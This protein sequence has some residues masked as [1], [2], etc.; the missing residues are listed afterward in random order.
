MSLTN[1]PTYT[2]S[3]LT[4]GSNVYDIGTL[5]SD[6]TIEKQG[7]Y[8]SLTFD[9]S[10]NVAYFSNVTVGTVLDAPATRAFFHGNFVDTFSDGDVTTAASNGRFYADMSETT[11]AFGT[12]SVTSTT[13]TS[14]TYQLVVPTE[15]TGTNVLVV[16]GGG[17]G[18]TG[19]GWPTG[20]G[21]GE[22]QNLTNQT[23]SAGTYTIVVGNG[24][25][26]N[27]SGTNSSALGTT[28]NPGTSASNNGGTSG[29]GNGP[30]SNYG[31][32]ERGGGGGDA[33]VGGNA[34]DRTG[35]SGGDGSNVSWLDGSVYGEQVS[36][37]AYFGGGG[38]SGD[39]TGSQTN[40]K[41]NG[42]PGTGGGGTLGGIG[43][44]GMIAIYSSVGLGIKYIG[45]D[46]YNKLSLS[47]ITNPTSKI[48]ALPTGAESTTT[49]DIGS[50]TNIYI[51][52]EGTYTAEMKGATRF[53]LDSTVVSGTISFPSRTSYRYLAL[54]FPRNNFENSMQNMII[55]FDDG[56]KFD[57][58]NQPA[59]SAFTQNYAPSTG[60]TTDV[61]STSQHNVWN[62]SSLG[63]SAGTWY[64]PFHIDCGSDFT[65][66]VKR[67]TIINRISD[68][69][70][71]LIAPRL[72]GASSVPS[73]PGLAAN[74]NYVCHVE[75]IQ[76]GWTSTLTSY[77][78]EPKAYRYIGLVGY[79]TKFTMH[80]Y[81]F[82]I[83]LVD[84]TVYDGSNIPT[85]SSNMTISSGS[86]A[87][88]IDGDF[89][90]RANWNSGSTYTSA[91]QQY[92][93]L[94]VDLGSA[95]KVKHVRVWSNYVGSYENGTNS[96]NYYGSST[97]TSSVNAEG[98]SDWNR[99]G[100]IEMLKSNDTTEQTINSSLYDSKL[101]FDGYNKLSL[102]KF[103]PTS[104]TLKY[105]SNTY[106]L[107]TISNVYIAYPGTYSAE[108]KGATNFA[109][110]SNITGSLGTYSTLHDNVAISH[111][112]GGGQTL[113][114]VN[115]I[116]GN[117]T[118]KIS[119]NKQWTDSHASYSTRL[120]MYIRD[121][122]DVNIRQI[123]SIGD[124]LNDPRDGI[125][126]Y[127]AGG[128]FD[129]SAMVVGTGFS[130]DGSA[131]THTVEIT[132]G[133][134]GSTSSPFTLADPW[135]FLLTM[136]TSD[137]ITGKFFVGDTEVISHFL[138]RPQSGT[139]GYSIGETGNKFVFEF[140][141]TATISG[142]NMTVEEYNPAPKF[143][144]DTY[145][146]LTFTGLESGST[147]TLKYGSNTYDIGT[148]SNVYISE[149]GTY[150]AESKGT[151]TFALTSNTALNVTEY[152]STGLDTVIFSKI[153][154]SSWTA[155]STI[156]DI[157]L[158]DANDN[159]LTIEYFYFPNSN[160]GNGRD[161]EYINSSSG[162]L[163]SNVTDGS[164]SLADPVN[165]TEYAYRNTPDSDK[166]MSFLSTTF[167]GYADGTEIIH[168]KAVSGE[169]A[170]VRVVWDREIYRQ[171][172]RISNKGKTYDITVGSNSYQG[173]DETYTLGGTY[174]ATSFISFDT[175]NKL[176]IQNITPTSTTL[177]YGSNTYEIG[178]ATNIYVENTGDYSAEIGNATDFALTNTTVSG[179][180]KT[181][182]PTLSG[183]YFFGHALTY[184]GKLYGWGENSN[185]ELGVGDNTDKTVPTLCTGI[186][187]G[188]VVSIWN[189]SKRSQNQWAKTRDGKIWVTGEG[190]QYN[191]PGQTSNQTSFIDVTSYF[192]DQSLTANN[193]THISGHGVRTVAALT[194]TGNV[195]TWGTHISSQWNLGQGTG[196]S[197]SN[198]PKQITFGGVTDNITRFE[199]G[200]A[201]GVALDTDGDVWFWGQIW[202][203][204]AGVDYPQ[205]TLS[206]AQK[207]PHEIMTS[208]NIIG[209]SSTYFTIYAW[210]S[211][212]TYYALGQDSAG[213]IGDGTA[214]AGGHT[215]W[216]KVDYFSANNITINEIYGGAYH[217][218]AD[219]SDGYYCWGG[220]TH[221]N[222]G[223]GSTGNLASPTKWTNVSNIKVFSSGSYECPY[224]ITEDGK[225]YAWGNGTNNARGD[226]TTGD[227]TY[228]KYIDTLPNILA[229]SFDY[230]GYDKVFVN[231]PYTQGQ[232][233]KFS[234]TTQT[235]PKQILITDVRI[236]DKNGNILPIEY[237]Y[238]PLGNGGPN[239]DLEYIRPSDSLFS[240]VTDG[241]YSSVDSGALRNSPES[242]R[243][244]HAP[245]S[246]YNTYPIG[247]EWMHVKAMSGSIVQVQIVWDRQQY[248]QPT[249]LDADGMTY[250]IPQGN[251]STLAGQDST[252]T[253]TGSYTS[254]KSS[255]YT[256]D[257]HTYDT[258][259]TQI[260]T[261]SDP[262]TYDAQI[263]SGTNFNLKSATI[264]AT[265]TSGL[266]TWAFHHGNFDNAYGDGDILTARDNGRFYADTPSYTGD[267][268]TITPVN[269]LVSSNV[270]FRLNE[271]TQN[272]SSDTNTTGIML[273]EI[274]VFDDT[275]TAMTYGT[276][277]RAD[278]YRAAYADNSG[279]GGTGKL[280]D[281]TTPYNEDGSRLNDNVL[282]G[283]GGYIGW[284][285]GT[286]NA[287]ATGLDRKYPYSVDD[288]LIR[289]VPL[290]GKII[291]KVQFAYKGT[292]TTPG[293]KVYRGDNLIETTNYAGTDINTQGNQTTHQI[294]DTVSSTTYTFTPAST[295]TANVLMVAGGGGG[296]QTSGG[297]A[298]GGGA[299]GLVYTAGTSLAQGAT[300][301]I[302]VGNGGAN[303]S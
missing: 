221:G 292:G 210:Q 288:E 12:V 220:G 121:S 82:S 237:I 128:S 125:L 266:Y 152:S 47:G 71:S 300:K 282:D 109:L 158:K 107:G 123:N 10:S 18:G 14:T 26:T 224:A 218:F 291:G 248:I 29:S 233:V 213:Q 245:D 167:N 126:L 175:Y 124:Y 151:T 297:S 173:L 98:S 274:D 53:A 205:T 143:D 20:G 254:E 41:G 78:M 15:L 268:G 241:S 264:P 286:Y 272:D 171:P 24:G 182:E 70:Y 230:D 65:K 194:E 257:T 186:P 246:V 89:T 154:G 249:K 144:F 35:G 166:I 87:N 180:L 250:D 294:A 185:G 296:G 148:A 44:G 39:Y 299:G 196:A 113:V 9:T 58:A 56:T 238:F 13:S 255:K 4:Y 290:T 160:G 219:T 33:S 225:Y 199:I 90:S 156:T 229:P 8:A 52:S 2:S 134:Y 187:Q 279:D 99:L 104:S 133:T 153:S 191:I 242:N 149:Q 64:C 188:E 226:N 136:S 155:N 263:K 276:D 1:T 232:I 140:W 50:A 11:T 227:I 137:V 243:L 217:V 214:T 68:Y 178:T 60:A 108:I 298:G 96:M 119:F 293:W 72:Y 170:K 162:T 118:Y 94:K 195:W 6:I 278:L 73:T 34:G 61:F 216:Q 239:Q 23:I 295:L 46:T 163:F 174:N 138:T 17:G 36:G 3:K 267:I 57:N 271:Y 177:K 256:K 100:P 287:S 122:S 101:E 91:S 235:W 222:L 231:N 31:Q 236:K 92:V 103:D 40:G 198:T 84:G 275:N 223:N 67:V 45:F 280:S 161:L 262:G 251:Q 244:I 157:Q 105:F 247:T 202:A 303:H 21:G 208:N 260:V 273:T 283:P 285:N 85:V 139:S 252:Y 37:Q 129:E 54:A 181:V 22:V 88:T 5:T 142:V 192:G 189:K 183:G 184:D 301:T 32:Y 27:A 106:D 145:N 190:T 69:Q 25:G 284:V 79:R 201:H 111:T 42:L 209:V 281:E 234:K 16:G 277:Y 197:S 30:G 258:K 43:R 48:H 270:S 19:S 86:A 179:T 115:N 114:T 269:P 165:S 240:T 146:K 228:P 127:D 131:G 212:G 172:M 193:I 81:E 55:E 132:G 302:V 159:L 77:D 49:Y 203:N 7:E 253:L 80:I 135:Y 168:V 97:N 62:G 261:V 259:D 130:V 120:K 215:S 93:Y 150:E 147:S 76:N 63:W 74:W 28:A 117:K 83:E 116:K 141:D 204:G 66:K 200:N 289:L 51:E 95:K 176:S 206:D 164:Y 169:V 112:T 110:S 102:N 75:S 59:N 265:K 211:D 38:Y 207:S